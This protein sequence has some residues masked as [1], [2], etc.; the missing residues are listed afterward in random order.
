MNMVL[1]RQRGS[2]PRIILPSTRLLVLPN[3]L[4]LPLPRLIGRL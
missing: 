4:L 3:S 1:P 2:A